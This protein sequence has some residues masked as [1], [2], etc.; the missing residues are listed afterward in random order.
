MSILVAC[1]DFTD[2]GKNKIILSWS[3]DGIN[4]EYLQPLEPPIF[5]EKLDPPWDELDVNYFDFVGDPSVDSGFRSIK[6]LETDIMTDPGGFFLVAAVAAKNQQ[7]P[8]DASIIVYPIST[9]NIEP[10]NINTPVAGKDYAF[11]VSLGHGKEIWNDKPN[12]AI[13]KSGGSPYLGRSY[14]SYTR[15]YNINNPGGIPSEHSEILIQRSEDYGLTWSDP[16]RLSEPFNRLSRLTTT[17]GKSLRD[18]GKTLLFTNN[19]IINDASSGSFAVSLEAMD[20]IT[21]HFKVTIVITGAPKIQ[22]DYTV[23]KPYN[24]H[25]LSFEIYRAYG[26]NKGDHIDFFLNGDL[27][28]TLLTPY[29]KNQVW[30]S[31]TTVGPEG[32]IYIGWIE[33]DELPEDTNFQTA[34]FNIRRSDDGGITFDSIAHV[35]TL[36]KVPDPFD[37]TKN[38]ML[39]FNLNLNVLTQANLAVDT[40][41]GDFKGRVYA[42]WQQAYRHPD[43]GLL[44]AVVML[45]FSDDKG[46]TWSFPKIVSPMAKTMYNIFPSITVSRNTGRVAIVFYSNACTSTSPSPGAPPTNPSWLDVMAV[47]WDGDVPYDFSSKTRLLTNQPFDPTDTS[48]L[49]KR[50]GGEN[51]IGDYIG[52][53]MVPPDKLVTVWTDTR[54]IFENIS[55]VLEP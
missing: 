21:S 42:V 39:G 15:L 20:N 32:Q 33:T 7:D 50:F 19:T 45:S 54:A 6:S 13:D 16:I 22:D 44:P 43:F 14:I 46:N 51:W 28:E 29:P 26:F 11:I 53:A 41:T 48:T 31:S 25:G 47:E 30:G 8:T 49:T 37:T 23:G 35:S 36:L 40:S 52:A 5:R 1:Q 2:H 38:P 34:S 17:G 18:A 3:K 12:L 9:A 10:D 27:P 4:F 55:S 24:K